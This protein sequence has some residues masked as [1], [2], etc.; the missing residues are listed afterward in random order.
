MKTKTKHA[1]SSVCFDRLIAIASFALV[2][3]MADFTKANDG[4]LDVENEFAA[5]GTILEVATRDGRL[6]YVG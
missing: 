6:R 2:L 1:S 4:V 5:V 3:L